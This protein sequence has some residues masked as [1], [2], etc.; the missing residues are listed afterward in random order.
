MVKYEQFEHKADV[1]IRGYGKTIKEAFENGARAMF[2]VT[3]NLEKVEPEKEIKIECE[4]AN[5]EELFVE[6]LNKLLSE[7]GIEN[8]IFSNFEVNEIK[9]VHSR[10]KLL[11]AARGEKLNLE[12]HEPKTEVKAAT[13]SQLKVEKRENQYMAQTIVDV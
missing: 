11:G 7:A 3:G 8:L 10:Y 12:R 5:L 4:A 1:G 13:Y 6:W 9:M 2:S